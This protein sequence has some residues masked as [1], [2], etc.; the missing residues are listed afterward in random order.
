MPPAA[1]GW[2]PKI[3]P[4]TCLTISYCLGLLMGSATTTSLSLLR[5]CGTAPWSRRALH[6]LCWGHPPLLPLSSSWEVPLCWSLT[7][8]FTSRIF[9]HSK[10][11][12]L[13]ML[14][15]SEE[16][17][18]TVKIRKALSVFLINV[19]GFKM[20]DTK[21]EEGKLQ[22]YSQWCH[23]L[24]S[25]RWS[26]WHSSDCPSFCATSVTLCPARG[27]V[28]ITAWVIC[29]QVCISSQKK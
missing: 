29:V 1:P 13:Y 24:Q 11:I 19:A 4:W 3:G 18:S 25:S 6:A 7:E 26:H 23:H 20:Q 12:C 8:A 28:Q 27:T 15:Q 5:S 10:L 9:F 17:S 14:K 16:T 21:S 2:A 22:S